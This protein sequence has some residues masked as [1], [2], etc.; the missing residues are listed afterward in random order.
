M[1]FLSSAPAT[2]KGSEQ[3]CCLAG[4]QPHGAESVAHDSLPGSCLSA[5]AV[6]RGQPSLAPF[7]HSPIPRCKFFCPVTSLWSRPPTPLLT[8]FLICCQ[9]W[10]QTHAPFLRG[11]SASFHSKVFLCLNRWHI[12]VAPENETQRKVPPPFLPLETTHLICF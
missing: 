2:C 3:G 8:F 7:H 4:P 12:P 9:T 1:T 10:A 11:T 5:T 6:S